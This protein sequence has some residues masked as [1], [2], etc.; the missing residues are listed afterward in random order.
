MCLLCAAL[1][2]QDPSAQWQS[3]A[4][5]GNSIAAATPSQL[6]QLA[7]YLRFGF[8]NDGGEGARS[9]DVSP[10]GRLTFDATGLSSQ[11]RFIAVSA[12]QAWTDVSGIKFKAIDN[13]RFSERTELGDIA[14][15]SNGQFTLG[16]NQMLNGTIAGNTDKDFIKVNL[17]AGT[18]YYALL[19]HEAR[20]SGN[21]DLVLELRD[22][23]G[24]LIKYSDAPGKSSSE[25]L[26][27]RVN[28]TGTYYLVAKSFQDNSQGKYELTFKKAADIV[29]DNWNDGA[30]SYSDIKSNGLINTSIVNVQ[31]NWD[32][33]PVS[34]NSYWLQTYIHEIGHALGLGHA[35]N[36]NGSANFGP[37]HK[38]AFDSWQASIMSYFSQTDNPNIDASFAFIASAMPADILAIQ[39][40]YG[41]NVRTRH[42]DTT[43]GANS[44]FSGYV[45]QMFEIIFDGAAKNPA[46]YKNNPVSLTLYDTGGND[47]IDLSPVR[48]NQRVNLNALESSSVA[49]G[50]GNLLIGPDVVIENLIGGRRSD[51]VI[52]N[53]S[54]NKFFGRD[55]G[56]RLNG[57]SGND[58]LNGGT[59]NDLLSGGS[60]DD[61]ILFLGDGRVVVNLSFGGTQNTGQGRDKLIS[62]ENVTTGTGNDKLLGNASDN[63]LSGGAG[64]DSLEGDAGNDRLNGSGGDDTLRGQEGNDT[65]SGGAGRDR[66][67]FIEGQDLIRDFR[68]DVDVIQISRSLLGAGNVTPADVLALGTVQGNSIVFDF[69]GGERLTVQGINDLDQLR[70][71][72][73]II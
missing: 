21:F 16:V 44:N 10:G 69:G 56:D 70:N 24:N 38:F 27:F 6:E 2:P 46:V 13:P 71:D 19:E 60:G 25:E 64:R 47:T 43:Y 35:G 37:D 52:G 62:I 36:Y 18:D 22:R 63:S 5:S 40:I 8:W 29:F 73:V 11:E 12:L 72:L 34:L 59:G 30:Y 54:N 15:N 41:G 67:V 14:D 17:K 50:V 65:L 4:G 20:R 23:N 49:G 55:G 1:R 42:G 51:T 61:T 3:H 48:Q 26:S 9:F 68:N 32:E 28:Q 31:S 66:F 53:S 33:K 39:D 57:K 58:T 7:D 45:R